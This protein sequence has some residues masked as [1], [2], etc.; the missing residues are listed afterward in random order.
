MPDGDGTGTGNVPGASAGKAGEAVQ[1]AS[2]AGFGKSFQEAS[3]AV[4]NLERGLRGLSEAGLSSDGSFEKL[5][6]STTS[7]YS[8]IQNLGQVLP[9]LLNSL[10][11]A[12]DLAGGLTKNL[13]QVFDVMIG[14]AA[15]QSMIAQFTD[16][17]DALSLG[18]RKTR[19]DMMA[20]SHAFGGTYDDAVKLADSFIEIQ[21]SGATRERGWLSRGQLDATIAAMKATNIEAENMTDTISVAGDAWSF[22]EL[23]TVHAQASSM[24]TTK[25]MQYLSNAMIKQGL[26]TSEAFKQMAG[27]A[28]VSEETGLTVDT[29]ANTLQNAT[30]NFAKLGVSADFARPLMIGFASSLQE[31]GLG[32]EQAGSLTESLTKSLAGLGDDYGMAHFVSTMGGL[33]FGGGGGALGAGIGIQ[34]AMLEA[35]TTGDQ[36]ALGKQLAGAMRDTLEQFGGGRI[37]TVGEAAEDP[38]LQRTFYVQQQMLKEQFQM[39]GQDATRTLE[40]LSNLERAVDSGDVAQANKLAEQISSQVEGTDKTIDQIKKGNVYAAAQLM[41]AQKSTAMQAMML[42]EQAGGRTVEQLFKEADTMAAAYRDA[43]DTALSAS[44]IA[45]VEEMIDSI[46][47]K[48]PT[49][50]VTGAVA[51]SPEMME[52]LVAGGLSPGRTGGLNDIGISDDASVGGTDSAAT[53]QRIEKLLRD[54]RVIR[55]NLNGKDLGEFAEGGDGI[56]GPGGP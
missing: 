46:F 44:N 19:S 54:G 45:S 22:L 40:M 18:I 53:L 11:L 52:R 9:S 50:T 48:M 14:F 30:S 51:S 35:E 26:E 28:E 39:T 34:A 4:S 32:V 25:Y 31:V 3:K 24:E 15:A 41:E 17:F 1:G 49:G 47:K 43:A 29:I 5:I 20:L 8:A 38:A 21:K 12:G 56:P 23:A 16:V 36:A 27:F 55:L 2:A 7:F 6:S 33:D 13:T 10:G 42:R 37:V